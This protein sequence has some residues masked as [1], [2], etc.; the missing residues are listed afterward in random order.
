MV[1]LQ[2]AVWN[3]EDQTTMFLRNIVRSGR[4]SVRRLWNRRPIIPTN[5]KT[6]AVAVTKLNRLGNGSK[7]IVWIDCEMTGLDYKNDQ[8][9][10][11]CCI[12][13]DGNLNIMDKD[14]NGDNCYESV[15]HCDKKVMDSMNDWC[16]QHHGASGLTEKVINT[17][18]T[19]EQ[20][21]TEL[22]A[23]IKKFIPENN[24]GILAGNS[25]H[26]DRLFMLKDFPKVID[27]LFYRLIDVSTIM[28]VSKRHNNDLASVFPKKK[29]AHT[30]KKDILESIDQLKWYMEHYLKNSIET[31]KFVSQ[32]RKE[33]EKEQKILEEEKAK[34]EQDDQDEEKTDTNPKK[35]ELEDDNDSSVENTDSKKLKT[36]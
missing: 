5:E 16:V 4:G 33:I 31:S 28:E 3:D 10:E 14:P 7:P 18:K 29:T 36:E 2:S 12:I 21:E 13:T 27:H 32:R 30:A 6:A 22:L 9:I 24:V 1:G 20:V 8:I 25:I 26:M 17:T 15:I 35:R 23:Y 19:R 34:E 11:I